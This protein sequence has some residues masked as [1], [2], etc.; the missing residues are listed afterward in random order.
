MI[1]NRQ[2]WTFVENT[3]AI[4]DN[5][6]RHGL[7]WKTYYNIK[8]CSFTIV[9]SKASEEATKEVKKI[10]KKATSTNVK[11]IRGFLLKDDLSNA[12]V[13]LSNADDILQIGNQSARQEVIALTEL[14]ATKTKLALNNIFKEE[15]YTHFYVAITAETKLRAD[16]ISPMVSRSEKCNVRTKFEQI[17]YLISRHYHLFLN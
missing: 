3:V 6:H 7:N 4:N 11:G 2:E 15:K 14:E 17:F 13:L 16:G 1:S 12:Q 10:F 9:N 5:F 8:K